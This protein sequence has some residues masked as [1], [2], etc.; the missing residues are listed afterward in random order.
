MTR[1]LVALILA[2]ACAT[3]AYAS[4]TAPKQLAVT[5]DSSGITVVAK[6]LA[7]STNYAISC[8]ITNVN[9]GGGAD[10]SNANGKV[11]LALPLTPALVGQPASCWVRSGPNFNDPP[12]TFPN[13]KQAVFTGP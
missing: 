1:I 6:K 4:W 8:V 11:K 7:P 13:G 3:P 9:V 2:L 12:V 5:E 10:M